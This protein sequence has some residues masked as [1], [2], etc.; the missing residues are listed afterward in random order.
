MIIEIKWNNPLWVTDNRG[1]SLFWSK[2]RP[3]EP[4]SGIGGYL[5]RDDEGKKE[6]KK[7][8]DQKKPQIMGV[9]EES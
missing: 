2:K 1:N 5:L 8:Q 6:S 3:T 4:G 9:I 7:R